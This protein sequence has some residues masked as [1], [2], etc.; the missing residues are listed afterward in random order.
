[1]RFAKTP[2]SLGISAIEIRYGHLK[3]IGFEGMANKEERMGH[4][5]GKPD[6]VIYQG[7]KGEA[8]KCTP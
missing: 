8:N 2:F 5:C 7:F 3:C 1:M 4:P 6:V